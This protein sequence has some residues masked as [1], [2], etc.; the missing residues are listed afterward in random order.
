MQPETISGSNMLAGTESPFHV[1]M[2]VRVQE[3]CVIYTEDNVSCNRMSHMFHQVSYLQHH[4]PQEICFP[5]T[6]TITKMG[7]DFT[8]KG[9]F[10]VCVFEGK[11]DKSA[12]L[13]IA[14]C[15]WPF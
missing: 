7:P 2:K 5:T 6:Q 14:W 3:T 1:T 10:M 9:V 11:G 12:P 4:N 8:L 13:L 15:D